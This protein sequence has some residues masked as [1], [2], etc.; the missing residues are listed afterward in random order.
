MKDNIEKIDIGLLVSFKDHPFSD[1]NGL[2]NDELLQSIKDNGIL[3]P[4]IVRPIENDKFEI[5]SGHRR[6][7]ALKKLGVDEVSAII[8][9]LT[10]QEAIITMVDANLKREHILPSEK[11]FACKMK[12]EA[13]KH[14]GSKLSC[15]VGAKLRSD[16][17]IAIFSDESARQIQRYIRLTNLIPEI[18]KLVDED[19]MA[20][21]PA[22]E[23]S[24]LSLD[25]QHKLYEQIE[26]T[27]AMPSLSQAQRLRRLSADN[28]FFS[29]SIALI[30]NEEKPNQKEQLKFKTDDLKK[31]FPR[32]YTPKDMQEVII[33]LLE[34]WKRSREKDAR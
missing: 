20:L 5:I 9:E 18:L 27:D 26:Y 12:L 30:L 11:A 15:Q 19:R 28:N 21:T 14:Q 4:I 3:E 16:E 22:V 23:L 17:L 25:E 8:K 31:Y 1:R 2:E 24:Y 32:N 34:R 6:V 29:D 13:I 7:N 10:D 33:K